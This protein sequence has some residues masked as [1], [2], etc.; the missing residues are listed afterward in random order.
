[1]AK[2][3][4]PLIICLLSFLL[5]SNQIFA[6]DTKISTLQ[7]QSIKE[8][9]KKSVKKL[10]I[11][12]NNNSMFHIS[13]HDSKFNTKPIIENSTDGIFTISLAANPTTGYQWFLEQYNDKLLNLIN[14]SFLPNNSDKK[15]I[16]AP[17]KAKWLFK[18]N[19]YMVKA[20]IMTTIKLVH[21]RAFDPNTEKNDSQEILTIFIQ[22]K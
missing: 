1:M 4:Q 15:L 22:P 10:S 11:N 14:Y 9:A 13:I 7:A 16:G 19:S 20:P 8:K 5:S 18:I 17:G 2:N 6:A 12:N 3:M 21:K